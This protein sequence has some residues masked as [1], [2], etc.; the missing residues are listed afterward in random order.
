MKS[1]HK[2]VNA[3]FT[4]GTVT[5]ILSSIIGVK[6]WDILGPI[7]FTIFIAVIMIAMR[8]MYDR[9]LCIF[10]TKK[11]F[12]LTG[13]RSTTKGI[14]FPLSDSEYTD[15]TAVLCG[16]RETLETFSP[17]LINHF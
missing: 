15:D 6:Q 16:S 7:L 5:H 3:K 11:D 2:N 17:L 14:Y 1:P 13:R 8:K 12:I 9:P 10:R 4:A